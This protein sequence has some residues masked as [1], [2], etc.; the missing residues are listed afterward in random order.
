MTELHLLAGDIGGTKVNLALFAGKGRSADSVFDPTTP[1]LAEATYAS[2]KYGSLTEVIRAFQQDYD[3][4]HIEGA[5]FG[6]AGPVVGGKVKATNLPWVVD[7]DELKQEFGWQTV[8]LL[9]DLVAMA[10]SVPI[11]SPD[12]LHTVQAGNRD[13]EGAIAV[14]APGTGLGEAFL[15][16]HHGEYIA[17][18]SEGGHADFSPSNAFELG[19]LNYLYPIYGHVST[20]RVCSGSGLPNIYNF[21]RDTHYADEPAYMT[22]ALLNVVDPTPIIANDALSDNPSPLAQKTLSMF[23]GILG[24]EAGDLALT[25]LATG[26]VYVGGGMPAKIMPA[27]TTPHFLQSITNKGRFSRFMEQ[28]PVHIILNPK[29]ALLGAARVG[30]ASLTA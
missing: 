22:E 7:A 3:I 1:P 29:A 4:S 17:H 16:F 15:T 10:D 28:V 30:F 24:S 8:V 2:D 23:V 18:P 12:D 11:L 27:L 25:Y 6:I 5:C 13:P 21:L 20:E 19:L 26:G 14:I 9:N